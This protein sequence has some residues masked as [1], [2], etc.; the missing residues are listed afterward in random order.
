MNPE[1]TMPEMVSAMTKFERMRK[2]FHDLAS[3]AYPGVAYP[4]MCWLFDAVLDVDAKLIVQEP[5][6][7]KSYTSFVLNADG[8]RELIMSKNGYAVTRKVK[9][10][11]TPR[12][13]ELVRE[14]WPLLP[15]EMK[16]D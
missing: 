4:E 1:D 16:I 2:T 9:R 11:F 3:E 13:Q 5:I 10:K 7:K 8:S 15:H 14:W 6:S 12:Q